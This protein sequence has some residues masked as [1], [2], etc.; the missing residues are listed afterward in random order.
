MSNNEIL[1]RLQSILGLN[2]KSMLEIFTFVD[3]DINANRLNG[4]LKDKDDKDFLDCGA[5]AL[6]HFLDGLII[7]KRGWSDKKSDED[8]R[9]NNNIIL[10]K[11]RIAF[12]LKETDLYEIFESV[13]IE[14]S[15]NELSSLFRKEEHKNFRLCPDSI[16]ELFL[17]GLT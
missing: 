16:L 15:K 5:N 3:F 8:I 14:I 6:G 9:L 12:E 17:D 1:K 4:Y 7:Y 10:K 13:G 11:L 2:E